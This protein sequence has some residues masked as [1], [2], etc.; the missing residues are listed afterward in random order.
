MLTQLGR[1]S[2]HVNGTRGALFEIT[3]WS[4][5]YTFGGKGA[6]V[7]FVKRLKHEQLLY[8]NITPIQ[9]IRVQMVPALIFAGPSL[10]MA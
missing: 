4:H 6:P 7:E 3:L 2:L 10:M 1:E 5:G 8:S 9:G